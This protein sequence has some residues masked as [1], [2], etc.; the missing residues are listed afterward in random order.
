MIP[1]DERGLEHW[2]QDPWQIDA[3]HDGKTLTDGAA[4]LLPYYW[5]DTTVSFG[6]SGIAGRSLRGFT[7]GVRGSRAGGPG[8]ARRV[9]CLL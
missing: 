7:R 2:N 8:N 9:Q 1:V 6:S 3:A 4:F 5:A